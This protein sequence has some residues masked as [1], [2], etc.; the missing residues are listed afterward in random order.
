M[1]EFEPKARS[2]VRVPA[3]TSNLGASFDT[4][5]LSLALY[6]TVEVE[7][8]ED[9]FEIIAAGEGA[10]VVPR[11]ESNLIARVARYVSERRARRIGGARLY[12][13]NQI[14]LARGLGSSSAAIIAGISIYEILSGERL[15][16]DEFFSCALHFEG[17]GDNLAPCLLG[18]LVTAC[19]VERGEEKTLLT[20]KRAWPEEIKVVVVVPEIELETKRMREALPSLV[21]ME[22]A[23]FNVQR[24]ALLQAALSERRFDLI[25]EALRDRLHQIYRAPLVP[26]LNDVLSMND[27]IDRDQCQPGL[28]GVA[29][30][31]AGSTMVAFV[32]ERAE[33]IGRA[34]E[35]RIARHGIRAR[36][37][38]LAVDGEGRRF[39]TKND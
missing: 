1:D 9:S 24:A 15:S 29:I 5:G 21:P 2:A 3:S 18:G 23:V 25:G 32:T 7:P 13:D 4:C 20:V 38:T 30:S 31:G 34:I 22:D 16:E 17:H 33:E 35:E 8:R 19:V 6:L 11:D 37:M 28:L 14:P 39:D 12:V 27:G 36:R 10:S 26:A